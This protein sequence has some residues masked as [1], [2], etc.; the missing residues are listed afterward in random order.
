MANRDP[1]AFN[2]PHGLFLTFLGL[3]L[4]GD[5]SWSWWIIFIPLAWSIIAGTIN[6]GARK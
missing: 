4:A 2:F 5:I 6:A 3:K 1:Y